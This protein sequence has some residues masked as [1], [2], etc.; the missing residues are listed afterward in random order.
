MWSKI[1]IFILVCALFVFF[2]A[3]LEI[4]AQTTY[5]LLAPLPEG[6]AEVPTD[7]GFSIYAADLFRFLL[8]GAVILALVMLV[9]GGGEYVGSAGNTS[10]LGD[11][12]G[13]MLNA[14]LGLLLAL[15]SW[16]ILNLINPDLVDFSIDVPEITTTPPPKQPPKPPPPLCSLTL[17]NPDGC[18]CSS[19]TQCL[20]GFCTSGKC[21]LPST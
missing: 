1:V 14:I 13:R 11:A 6:D 7:I 15:S 9:I 18:P 16:L 4:N 19:I 20:T 21:G 5:K 3:N 2:H 8:S 12:K 17:P 10:L